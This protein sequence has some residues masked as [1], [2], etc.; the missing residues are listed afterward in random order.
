MQPLEQELYD[1]VSNELHEIAWHKNYPLHPNVAVWCFLEGFR[2]RGAVVEMGKDAV[3][4][5]IPLVFGDTVHSFQTER[6][7][8]SVLRGWKR[9]PR[10]SPKALYDSI[11]DVHDEFL[12]G[13]PYDNRESYNFRRGNSTETRRSME[14]HLL[15]FFERYHEHVL[16]PISG[17]ILVLREPQ[18]FQHVL[19]AYPLDLLRS[20]Q[21]MD[22]FASEVRCT[23][24]PETLLEID[25][26][27]DEE[28][29]PSSAV[30]VDF[31]FGHYLE[32]LAREKGYITKD[33]GDLLRRFVGGGRS[34]LP[35]GHVL[36]DTRV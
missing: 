6:N 4:L 25:W 24:C 27:F 11:Y 14:R 31:F 21:V 35:E 2:D 33:C 29:H 30:M 8:E 7:I 10:G 3:R 17:E 1:I 34:A 28:Y 12:K 26:E 16:M 5:T 20:A 23:P 22:S 19:D 18:I 15:T 9:F 36:W 32:K 13:Q